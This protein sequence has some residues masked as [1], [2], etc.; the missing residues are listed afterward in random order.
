MKDL[1]SSFALLRTSFTEFTLRSFTPFRMT[2]RGIHPERSEGFKMTK[3]PD[4]LI[5]P[6]SRRR[7]MG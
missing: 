1:M 4:S 3:H 5:T 2:L 7:E 6:V